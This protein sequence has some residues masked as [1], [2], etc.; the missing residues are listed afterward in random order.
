M[1]AGI[2]SGQQGDV[3][4]VSSSGVQGPQPKTGAGSSATGDTPIVSCFS[5][6]KSEQVLLATAL[7]NAESKNGN[8]ILR[9][10]LDQG[11]QANLVTE[12]VVQDLKLHKQP[13]NVKITGIG[14]GDEVVSKAQVTIQIRS[15]VNPNS[16]V[17]VQAFVLKTITTFLPH[18]RVGA[19]EWPGLEGVTLADPQWKKPHKIDLLLGAGIYS[20]VIQEGLK[21]DPVGSLVAQAT[22]LGWIISGEIDASPNPGAGLV[23]LHCQIRGEDDMLRKFWELESDVSLTGASK[24]TK[25]EAK[26]KEIFTAT[27]TRDQDTRYVVRL[28]FKTEDPDC[29]RGDTRSIAEKRVKQLEKLQPTVEFA[30]LLVFYRV[31]RETSS[32]YSIFHGT[33]F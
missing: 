13:A 9:A 1:H 19:L 32:A 25:D 26:C 8:H 3:A 10:L 4:R 29:K 24:L 23:S 16:V 5:N 18:R 15:R 21:K 30:L 20:K 6:G 7:V 2:V 14:D 22:T 12:S 17:P 33:D 11:S 27:T 28:P 31:I